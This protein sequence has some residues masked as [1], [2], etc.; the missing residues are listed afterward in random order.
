MVAVVIAS[1][2]LYQMVLPEHRK[3]AAL[4]SLTTLGVCASVALQPH[5]QAVLMAVLGSGVLGLVGGLAAPEPVEKAAN[6]LGWLVA[7]PSYLGTCFGVLIL[8]SMQENGGLWVILAMFFAFGSDTGGYFAGK[9][10]GKHKLYPKVSPKKTVEGSIGGLV[11]TAAGAVAAHFWFL[12]ELPL[13]DGIILGVIAGALGQLGDLCVSLI[14][15]ST[16]V[17]DSGSLIPGHGG[18]LDRI[19]ALAFTGAATWLYFALFISA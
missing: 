12:P 16:G 8:L 15:R 14:K 2:E 18:L 4:G 10:F 17:K 3:L 1:R 9:F 13:V 11:V 19:D 5:P 7:G 6:R